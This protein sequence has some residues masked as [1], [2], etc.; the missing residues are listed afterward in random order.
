M[1][2]VKTRDKLKIMGIYL[3]GFI[4]KQKCKENICVVI[5][6]SYRNFICNNG[7]KVKNRMILLSG[8]WIYLLKLE[9]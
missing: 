2:D 7:I 9:K 3:F 5:S 8:V 6:G 4:C 1:G